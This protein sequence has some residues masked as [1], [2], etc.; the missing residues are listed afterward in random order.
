MIVSVC[1]LMW[2]RV[3]VVLLLVCLFADWLLDGLLAC[4]LARWFLLLVVCSCMLLVAGFA[5]FVVW[6]FV[7]FCLQLVAVCCC[8][9]VLAVSCP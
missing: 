5:C 9:C 3:D 1:L 2:L 6:C 4:V 8:S 7:L